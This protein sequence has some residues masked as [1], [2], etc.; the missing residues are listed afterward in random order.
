MALAVTY[1]SVWLS[2]GARGRYYMPLYPCLAVLV[3]MV[4]ERAAA[5]DASYELRRGWRWFC[6]G[7]AAAMLVGS[8]VLIVAALNV[9]RPWLRWPKAGPTS[10]RSRCW[11]AGWPGGCLR[12]GPP[13]RR[14]RAMRP[15]W[16]CSVMVGLAFDGAAITRPAPRHARSDR[17]RSPTLQ[18]Q[19]PAAERLVSFGPVAH[20]FAYCY[21]LPIAELAWPTD[22]DSVP[23]DVDYF[24]F[25]QHP[26]DN[27][28]VRQNGRGSFWGTTSGTLPFE[29]T[30]VAAVP[31]TPYRNQDAAKSVIVGRIVRHAPTAAADTTARRAIIAARR[32]RFQIDIQ[33]RCL[34]ASRRG[35]GCLTA[36]AVAGRR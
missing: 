14:P 7:I 19:L 30:Q 12:T 18:S 36:K 23:A 34:A 32:I 5:A 6:W 15:C 4:I 1:P 25:E 33:P 20:R 11:P 16:P 10:C 35:C 29:W 21:G 8:G 31:Y 3:G 17:P 9:V 13:P 26:G 22:A 24:C 28:E 27:A 2:A